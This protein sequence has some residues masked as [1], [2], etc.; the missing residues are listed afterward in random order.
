[1]K[2]YSFFSF[3]NEAAI[4]PMSVDE[5]TGEVIEISSIRGIETPDQEIVTV[6]DMSLSVREILR[7]FTSGTIELNSLL[8]NCSESPSGDDIDDDRFDG[9]NDLVDIQERLGYSRDEVLQILRDHSESLNSPG[10]DASGEET[11]SE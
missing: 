8:N 9:I 5:D 6:P 10:R 11:A 2:T 1:M 3:V 4:S 7:R